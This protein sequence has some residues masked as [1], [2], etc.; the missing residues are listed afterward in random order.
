MDW[1]CEIYQRIVDWCSK[2]SGLAGSGQES[3]YFHRNVSS[4]LHDLFYSLKT[5]AC[6]PEITG[7][8]LSGYS[9]PCSPQFYNIYILLVNKWT[10][11]QISVNI[12][13]I[14]K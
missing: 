2:V 7:P 9:Q 1:N 4:F 3:T 10:M 12:L 14:A 8:V 6:E 11:R 5:G 13:T